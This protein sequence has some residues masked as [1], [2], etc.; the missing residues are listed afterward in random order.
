M[1]IIVVDDERLAL[2]T[3]E[4]A[5]RKAVDDKSIISC[6]QYPE[7]AL[8]YAKSHTVDVAFL[9]IQMDELSGLILAKKLKE[10]NKFT[11]IIFVTGHDEYTTNAFNLHASGYVLK[12]MSKDRVA[13]EL[14][15]LRSPVSSPSAGVKIR[16]FGYFDIFVDGKPLIFGRSKSKEILAY[17]V[18][19]NGASVSKRELASML[20]ENKKYT[21]NIQGHTYILIS[22]MIEVLEKAGINDLVIKQDGYYSVDTGLYECDYYD[23]LKGD[24]K[25]INSY[26]GEYMSNY[27]WAEFTAGMLSNR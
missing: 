20:W 5:I 2:K 1:N 11:N 10:I 27:S 13:T 21:R 22:S 16:C 14:A 4:K 8:G 15:N 17:L 24:V 6:F 25:A 3:H 9:D 18:D 26:H 7:D 19:R 23:Y 12:P